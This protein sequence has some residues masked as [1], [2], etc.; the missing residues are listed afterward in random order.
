MLHIRVEA[1]VAQVIFY[2][3]IDKENSNTSAVFELLEEMVAFGYTEMVSLTN[4]F[5]FCRLN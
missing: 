4:I 5:N 1:K 2:D 3:G